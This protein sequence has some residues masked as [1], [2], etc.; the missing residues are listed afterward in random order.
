MGKRKT[1]KMKKS[2]HTKSSKRGGSRKDA[3][4]S[5]ITYGDDKY[6]NQKAIILRQANEMGSFNG[7]IQA[8]GPEDL[9]E[10]FKQAVGNVINEARGGGYWIWKPY[11][12]MDIMSK[13]NENDIFLYADAGCVLQPS[14]VNRLKEYAEMI[15]PESGKSVLCMRLRPYDQ[16]TW[17][18]NEIFKYF[19]EDP[20]GEIGNA[21]QVLATIQMYR[22]CPESM[23][24][25]QKFYDIARTRPDLF[26][27][28]HNEETKRVRPEFA[29][30]R[31]DQSIFS[32]LVQTSPYNKSSVIIEEEIEKYDPINV[33]NNSYFITKPLRARRLR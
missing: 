27:D 32:M 31:H 12:F 26:T 14:G 1:R 24:V 9:S 2:K 11:I 13:L 4:L 30:N 7:I 5:F 29:D 3:T 8:Y 10:D 6:N 28:K 25:I 15:S 16:K 23:A 21:K 18:T 17:T 20:N 19:N 33:R 22:K